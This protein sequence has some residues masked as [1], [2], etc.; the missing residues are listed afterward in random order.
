MLTIMYIALLTIIYIALQFL[1]SCLQVESYVPERR[2][3]G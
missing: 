3:G 1:R 2:E